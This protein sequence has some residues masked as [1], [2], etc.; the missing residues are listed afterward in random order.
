MFGNESAILG[1]AGELVGSYKLRVASW[2]GGHDGGT[3][4]KEGGDELHLDGLV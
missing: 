2:D 1:F 3:C 4:S